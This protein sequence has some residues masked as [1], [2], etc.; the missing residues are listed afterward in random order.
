[1]GNIFDLGKKYVEAF[2]LGYIDRDGVKKYPVMGCYGIGI[3]R[4]MGVIVEKFNDDR[5]IVWP[6]AVAPYRIGL[7]TLD[8]KL[9]ESERIYRTLTDKGVE[10]LWDERKLNAGEKFADA[11]L[12][13]CPYRVVV[14]QRSL[15]AGGVEVKKRKETGSRNVT[16]EELLKLLN[17]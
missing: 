3:S 12:I 16:V 4:T 13:G 6:E 9:E 15:Q 11:D 14:S 8:D 7:L 17:V 1:M 5:G 10:V 2:D